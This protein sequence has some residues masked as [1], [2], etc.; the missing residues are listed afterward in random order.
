MT[1]PR[2]VVVVEASDETPMPL[3]AEESQLDSETVTEEEVVEEVKVD[4]EPQKEEGVLFADLGLSV[5]VKMAEKSTF[6]DPI[7]KEEL[8]DVKGVVL[9]PGDTLPLNRLPPYLVKSLKDGKV[10]GGR[11][12]SVE[13]AKTLNEEAAKV[14]ALVGQTIGVESDMITEIVTPK[15]T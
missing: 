4:D 3:N 7:T 6:T 12:V 5:H 14:R 15:E 9:A 1:R 11:I 10:P 13:E 8:W 2:K